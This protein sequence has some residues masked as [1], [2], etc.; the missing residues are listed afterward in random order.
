MSY[1]HLLLKHPSCNELQVSVLV[2]TDVIL[3]RQGS[4]KDPLAGFFSHYI[5]EQDLLND[6]STSYLSHFSCLGQPSFNGV[7]GFPQSCCCA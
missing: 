4:P 2:E 5:K 6:G 1:F 7:K 3:K